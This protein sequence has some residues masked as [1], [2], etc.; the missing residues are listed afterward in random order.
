MGKENSIKTGT[1]ISSKFSNNGVGLSAYN[2]NQS[3][4]KSIYSFAVVTF[5]NPVG[6]LI[7]YNM[8]ED[9]LG[10]TKTGTAIPLYPNKIIVPAIGSVVPLL[11][12]PDT[13]IST[14][15]GQYS[16]TTYYLDPIG[17]QQTVNGNTIIKEVPNTPAESNVN[18]IN[19]QNSI[20]GIPNNFKSVLNSLNASIISGYKA[21]VPNISFIKDSELDIV[22][23]PFSTNIGTVQELA[24][25]DGKPVGKDV[26]KAIILMKK[27]AAKDGVT[28]TV[29]SGFRSPYNPID[30][31]S[32]KGNQVTADSQTTLYKAYIADPEHKPY[33]KA[34][35]ESNHGNAFA[36]D[37]NTGSVTG[38][39]KESLNKEVYQWLIDNA[40]KFG[41]VR[42]EPGEEWHW[43]YRPGQ[44]Q[45]NSNV[46]KNN[47]LYKG[48]NT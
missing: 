15:S 4:P 33:T 18:N 47:F 14:N 21:L 30:K 46:P 43:E 7:S 13:N 34:P 37:L 42:W 9:N 11:R 23:G 25:V 3:L 17:V 39:I 45:Y 2:L 16:K 26:A 41:F 32:T 1:N 36:F 20:I 29:R 28:L 10:L 19:I 40:Y 22:K 31:I 12:A 44:Y 5:V 24:V 8:I 6:K 35:G 38:K 27:T 48:M